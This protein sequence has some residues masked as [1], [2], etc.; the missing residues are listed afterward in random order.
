MY[1]FLEPSDVWLFRDGRPF[2]A[3][4]D[5][6]ATSLFPPN[7]STV[8]GALRAKMLAESGVSFEDYRERRQGTEML[9]LQIGYPALISDG[10]VVEEGHTGQFQMRCLYVARRTDSSVELFFPLPADVVDVE[11]APRVLA[12][13]REPPFRNNTPQ[14]SLCPLWLPEINTPQ[15]MKG[16]LA[17]RELRHYL[18]GEPF[19]VTLDHELFTREPRFSVEIDSDYKRP[20][21]GEQGGHLYQ[22][23]FVRPQHGVGL[24]I[25][26]EG[27]TDWPPGFGVLRIGGESRAACYEQLEEAPRLPPTDPRRQH[28]KLY[29]ATPAYFSDGWQPRKGN[30]DRFF[31]DGVARLVAAALPRAQPIGGWDVAHNRQ[32]PMECYVPAGSVYYFEVPDGEQTPHIVGPV[33]EAGAKIGY[34]QTF[35]GGWDYV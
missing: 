23:E 10:R 5:H 6:R 3:G 18:S 11:G 7:P 19:Q 2:V 21:E 31:E 12:P 14:E 32:K 4:E 29:F 15:G 22:I 34:G 17:D 20:L 13:L 8:Q 9:G 25:E 26:V 30:W 27:L 28:F 35:V 33:T 24:F 1:L 16:W